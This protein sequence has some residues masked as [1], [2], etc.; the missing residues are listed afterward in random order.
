MSPAP[1][2]TVIIPTRNRLTLLKESLESV[3]SQEGVRCEVVVVDDD[4]SDGTGAWLQALG[5]PRV[6]VLQ[7]SACQR[8]AAARNR[9]LELA[10]GRHVMFLDDDDLLKPHALQILSGALDGAPQAV[11]AIGAREDWFTA[12]GYRRRDV[13]PRFPRQRDITNDLIAGWSAVPSQTLLRTHEAWEVGGYDATVVPCDDRDFLHRMTRRG[14]VVMRPEIVVTYRITPTQWRPK[15]I[16][17]LRERVA[18]RAIRSL[19][20]PSWRN[21]L[22]VRRLVRLLDE[23]EDQFASGSLI[24]GFRTLHCALLAA[25]HSRLSPLVVIWIARRLAGRIARRVIRPKFIYVGER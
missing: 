20:R 24:V 21:A 6:T 14:P 17:Q 22:K 18:R 10:R 3:L 16:R 23:T 2:V 9:G 25:P 12:Q 7:Q 4:S 11:A 13:H 19:P 8:Q 5:N 1:D 15:N